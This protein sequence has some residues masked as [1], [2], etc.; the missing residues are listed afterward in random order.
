[1][2]L[3]DVSINRGWSIN[4]NSMVG[5]IRTTTDTLVISSGNGTTTIS[6]KIYNTIPTIASSSRTAMTQVSRALMRATVLRGMMTK[7][8]MK[9]KNDSAEH[10]YIDGDEV[11]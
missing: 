11:M 7:W 10:K 6:S 9:V 4:V 5:P 3:S 2:I 1:L 8:E